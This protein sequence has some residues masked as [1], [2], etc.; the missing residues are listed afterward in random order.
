MSNTKN[1]QVIFKST[2]LFGFI[3]VFNIISKMVLNKVVAI[4]IGTRGIGLIGLY[5][6]A[7]GMLKTGTSLG[8]S[9]SAVRDISEANE[10]NDIERLSKTIAT[11]NK[12]IIVTVFLGIFTTVVLSPLLSEWT[13]GDNLYKT[14]FVLISIAVA[15]TILW[16]GQLAILKGVR[17]LRLLA[18]ANIFGS[19]VGLIISIPMYFIYEMKGI[20]PVL[21][22]TPLSA[23]LLS[24][25]YVRKVNYIK[26]NLPFKEVYQRASSMVKMGLALSFTIL[27]SQVS[28]FGISAFI[29]SQGGLKSV[30]FFNAG[31]MIMV[32]YFSVIINALTTDYYPRIAAINNDNNKLQVELNQQS[33]VSLLILF[34]LIVLFLFSLPFLVTLLYS[35]EFYPIIDFVRIGIY[36]TLITICSNQIDLIL[37]AKNNTKVYTLVAIIYRVLDVLIKVFLYKFY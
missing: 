15:L 6:S 31:I 19:V 21:I 7:I 11:T 28:T 20:I 9:Q 1:Y 26:I 29:G 13:F 30:G 3:Q 22:I 16:E 25:Y 27:L 24:N 35:K 14:N 4:T 23:F 33:I 37:V 8:I 18:K 12:V 2:F 10:E 34:P 17:R 36:G 32:G 5:T